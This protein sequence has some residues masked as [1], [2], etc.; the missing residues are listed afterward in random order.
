MSYA[1]AFLC[2][3]LFLFVTERVETEKYRFQMELDP[4]WST[5]ESRR[6][7]ESR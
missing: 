6:F 3:A 5:L 4:H 7:W 2:M 1:L